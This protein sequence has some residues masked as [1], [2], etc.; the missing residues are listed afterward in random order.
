LPAIAV[1]PGEQ[2]R[3]SALPSSGDERVERL[4]GELRRLGEQLDH[5]A[6]AKARAP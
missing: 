6:A 1:E 2:V 5:A 4:G 3:G